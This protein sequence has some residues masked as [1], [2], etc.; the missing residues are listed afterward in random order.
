MSSGKK[1]A[2]TQHFNRIWMHTRNNPTVCKS[3]GKFSL[4]AAYYQ[5]RTSR[6]IGSKVYSNSHSFSNDFGSVLPKNGLYCTAEEATSDITRFREAVEFMNDRPGQGGSSAKCQ[7][8]SSPSR[9]SRRVANLEE[10]EGDVVVI[11]TLLSK[12]CKQRAV[13]RQE[14]RHY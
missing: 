10:E 6:K 13:Q 14:N 4:Y 3:K 8:F 7:N 9:H 2:K 5:K 11:K 12:V 1:K